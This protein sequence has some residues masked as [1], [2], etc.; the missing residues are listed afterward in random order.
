[1]LMRKIDVEME[2]LKTEELKNI[3]ASILSLL[4]THSNNRL[5]ITKCISIGG[6]RL[7]IETSEGI[8]IG[9]AILANGEKI[10]VSFSWICDFLINLRTGM[11]VKLNDTNAIIISVKREEREISDERKNVITVNTVSPIAIFN[12]IPDPL[13]LFNKYI[14]L[15]FISE[16]DLSKSWISEHRIKGRYNGRFYEINGFM[17]INIPSGIS[18]ELVEALGLGRIT[19]VGYGTVKTSLK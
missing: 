13:E 2:V 10:K 5:A 9:R 6:T 15:G 7:L 16:D 11:E 1:M 18:N 14:K 17:K 12:P 19:C 8:S 4:I 3:G